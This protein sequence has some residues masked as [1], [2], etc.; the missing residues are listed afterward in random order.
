MKWTERQKNILR[1][2][3]LCCPECHKSWQG[4]EF[5]KLYEAQMRETNKD[6]TD[7]ELRQKVKRVMKAEGLWRTCTSALI[8]DEKG[9]F[10]CPHCG[11]LYTYDTICKLLRQ[12]RLTIA[13][14]KIIVFIIKLFKR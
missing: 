13:I 14:S 12:N 8:E 9:V 1:S 6:I 11:Q 4:L 3:W 5:T 2:A 7:K 10:H